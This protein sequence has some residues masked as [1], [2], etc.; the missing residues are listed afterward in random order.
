MSVRVSAS[1]SVRA[2]VSESESWIVNGNTG[3]I[4][5]L[6]ANL[7]LSASVILR[8]TRAQGLPQG[9]NPFST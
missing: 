6:T 7:G 2:S 4:S 9:L 8:V 3:M 1:S 5:S